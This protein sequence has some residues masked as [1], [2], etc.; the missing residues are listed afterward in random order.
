MNNKIY[1]ELDAYLC[2][3]NEVSDIKDFYRKLAFFCTVTPI[4]IYLYYTKSWNEWVIISVFLWALLLTIRALS[5]FKFGRH[6]EE[7]KIKELMN[8][9]K[10]HKNIAV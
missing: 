4:T 9:E 10:D 2:A 8:R 5:L 6:W 3:K 7:R 1:N